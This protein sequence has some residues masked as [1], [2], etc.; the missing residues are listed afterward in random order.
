M[1]ETA[2]AGA[3]FAKVGRMSYRPADAADAWDRIFGFFDTYPQEP[4][5]A[6]A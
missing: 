2:G 6:S 3:V 5:Q 1:T 4:E